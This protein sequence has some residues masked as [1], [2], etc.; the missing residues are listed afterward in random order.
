MLATV[1]PLTDSVVL[2]VG[3][4]PQPQPEKESTLNT[5]DSGACGGVASSFFTAGGS[6]PS[7]DGVTTLAD[8]PAPEAMPQD[9]ERFMDDGA[10]IFSMS[11]TTTPTLEPIL[12][13]NAVVLSSNEG[14]PPSLL[15]VGSSQEMP[16]TD[17][18]DTSADRFAEAADRFMDDGASLI[19][20]PI[21]GKT[22]IPRDKAEPAQATMMTT[23]RFVAAVQATKGEPNA[24][25]RDGTVGNRDLFWNVGNRQHSI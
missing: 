17:T 20:L 5:P 8:P 18:E 13:A 16:A 15:F 25:T 14:S 11:I 23:D 12:M 3:E 2:G 6:L 10:S 1:D 19:S 21:S 9:L 24:P 22:S 7:T 4:G